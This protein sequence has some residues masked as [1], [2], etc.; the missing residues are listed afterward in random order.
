MDIEELCRKGWRIVNGDWR[1]QSTE[2]EI[3]LLR[4]TIGG[5]E[6]AAQ[7]VRY[8]QSIP[9][10]CGAGDAGGDVRGMKRRRETI[11]V[12]PTPLKRCQL[13]EHL[14]ISS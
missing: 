13:S 6:T 14:E 5:Q 11:A 12:L 1:M 9:A 8:S 3:N 4:G 10:G 2:G 7:A